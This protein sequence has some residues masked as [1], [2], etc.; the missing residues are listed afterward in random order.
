MGRPNRRPADKTKSKQYELFA[1]LLSTDEAKARFIKL[2]TDVLA[3]TW[4]PREPLGDSYLGE[5]YCEDD[6]GYLTTSWGHVGEQRITEYAS[7]AAEET[8]LIAE[9]VSALVRQRLVSPEAK[10]SAR[11]F[12]GRVLL[13]TNIDPKL[14]YPVMMLISPDASLTEIRQYLNDNQLMLRA[15]Q[16]IN[17]T[18]KPR[19]QIRSKRKREMYDV[20]YA[21]KD[22]PMDE[23][24]K[25]TDKMFPYAL[26]TDKEG[27]A[28]GAENIRAIIQ[29]ETKRRS[30]PEKSSG[31]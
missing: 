11:D 7:W 27:G 3:D 29:E 24:L 22:M 26:G 21:N 30:K 2:L 10:A 31:I 12:S 28:Y 9:N 23:L 5:L 19:K 18:S 25:L 14:P 20:I 8:G 17:R 6:G 15:M 1:D 16:G 13:K 4:E